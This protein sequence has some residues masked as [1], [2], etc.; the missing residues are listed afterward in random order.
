MKDENVMHCQWVFCSTNRNKVCVWDVSAVWQGWRLPAQA[1]TH[2]ILRTVLMVAAG[3][4]A[5]GAVGTQGRALRSH[6]SLL[7]I[8]STS[9]SFLRA[10]ANRHLSCPS[11]C[12]RPLASL[13]PPNT[14]SLSL[15]GLG[16]SLHGKANNR[17]LAWQEEWER[18]RGIS[19]EKVSVKCRG[20]QRKEK[21]ADC[22][23][24]LPILGSSWKTCWSVILEVIQG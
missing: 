22:I 11:G 19:Q 1:E 20:K 18:R 14:L 5:F 21:T 10:P 13:Q 7:S 4:G 2:N 9:Q 3:L 8:C 17:L 12:P 23:Q 16:M 6:L 15:P 24:R